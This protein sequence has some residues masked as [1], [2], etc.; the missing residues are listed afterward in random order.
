[1]VS[2]RSGPNEM[3]GPSTQIP[4][5]PCTSVNH[6]CGRQGLGNGGRTVEFLP[7]L[8]ETINLGIISVLNRTS[9][10]CQ[11]TTQ[12]AQQGCFS[13][14]RSSPPGQAARQRQDGAQHPA[15]SDARRMIY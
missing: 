11:I 5:R 12:Q 9:A 14:P 6:R 4:R 15:R 3:T 8:I 13:A 2:C 1:M 7:M 10:W